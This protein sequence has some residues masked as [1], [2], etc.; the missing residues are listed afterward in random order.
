MQHVAAVQDGEPDEDGRRRRDSRARR[1]LCP[2]LARHASSASM[3]YV[4]FSPAS[5]TKTIF[6]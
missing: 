1:A 6:Q 5:S 2:A 3:K 4:V